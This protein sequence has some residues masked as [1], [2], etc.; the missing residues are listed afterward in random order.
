MYFTKFSFITLFFTKSSYITMFW[1]LFL[2]FSS[3]ALRAVMFSTD[4]FNVFLLR[5]PTSSSRYQSNTSLCSDSF[6]HPSCRCI[7]SSNVCVVVNTTWFLHKYR[8]W[9]VLSLTTRKIFKRHVHC[10]RWGWIWKVL[11]W[12]YGFP[13]RVRL[14]SMWCL[15]SCANVDVTH[16]VLVVLS[17]VLAC[18]HMSIRF[19][20]STPKV[21]SAHHC[22]SFYSSFFFLFFLSVSATL[23]VYDFIPALPIKVISIIVLKRSRHS[24]LC[25]FV[26]L[27]CDASAAQPWQPLVLPRASG[28][29]PSNCNPQ[30]WRSRSFSVKRKF[31]C[32]F[33]LDS[34]LLSRSAT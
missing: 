10:R 13:Q 16:S 18:D 17:L 9:S 31:L 33:Q 32:Q 22:T 23:F 1:L 28:I 34:H 6:V 4:S 19:Q 3:K 29:L 26:A 30:Q 14:F 7:Q 11:L 24:L 8:V 2:L 5:S 21:P 27:P 12:F 20:L 25:R 15:R